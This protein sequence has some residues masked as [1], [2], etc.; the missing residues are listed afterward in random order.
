[1]CFSEMC[2]GDGGKDGAESHAQYIVSAVETKSQSVCM[3]SVM[4][5]Y[6]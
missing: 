3:L 2:R 1:M 4:Y 6:A 5:I